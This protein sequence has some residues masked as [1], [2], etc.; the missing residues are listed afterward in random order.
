[1]GS[2][3]RQQTACG[4]SPFRPARREAR[5]RPAGQ[6][7]VGRSARGLE[8]GSRSASRPTASQGRRSVRRSSASQRPQPVILQ[9][10]QSQRLQQRR[11]PPPRPRAR[12]ALK[13]SSLPLFLRRCCHGVLIATWNVPGWAAA[14]RSSTERRPQIVNETEPGVAPTR[15]WPLAGSMSSSVAVA[16]PLTAARKLPS[17]RV[18]IARSWG[19]NP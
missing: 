2:S 5:R 10:L 15:S 1:M 9:R 12:C 11:R 7:L 16:E 3:A 13:K 4:R 14:T 19:A 17:R 6:R 18:V 8:A